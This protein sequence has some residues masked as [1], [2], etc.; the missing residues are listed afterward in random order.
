MSITPDESPRGAGARW[1]LEQRLPLLIIVL[2]AAVLIGLGGAAHQEVREANID[3]AVEQLQRIGR[4]LS[5]SSSRGGAPRLVAL[6][7]LAADPLLVRAVTAAPSG[8]AIDSATTARVTQR[9][10]A[11]HTRTDSTLLGWELWTTSGAPRLRAAP[12]ASG[13]RDSA[14]LAHTR[15]RVAQTDSV[16]R[17]PFYVADGRVYVWTVVPVRA[18]GR[19][20]GTLAEHRRLVGSARTE[21]TI[22]ALTGPEVR[23]LITSDGEPAWVTL[24]GTP[25]EA[26]FVPPAANDRAERVRG[27][28]GTTYYAVQSAIAGTPWRVVLFTT[29]AAVLR[30][31]REFLRAML[32]A[33]VAFLV[34]GTFGA[35]LLSRHVTRPLRRITRAAA[36]LAEGDYTQRVPLAD[37]AELESLAATF[38][39][40]AAA[41][42]QAHGE[43]AERN[44]ALQRANE[45]K[46]RFLAVMSH[47]LRTPL[48][49]IGG[50][51]E[52][53]EL[54][55]RGPVTPEQIEDLG[56]IRRSKDYLLTIIQDILAFSRGD[57]GYLTV[58]V[59]DVPVAAVLA[60]A[61]DTLRPQYA[62][63]GIVLDVGAVPEEQVVRA[64]R[65][66]MQQILLNLLAN[67]LRFT[68]PGGTVS[69]RSVRLSQHVRI[70]VNDTGIGIAPER[71]TDIFEP[72]VQVDASLTRETGGA[73]LGLAIARD[74]AAAMG[75]SLTVASTV[76]EGSTFTLMLPLATGAEPA[77]DATPVS[78]AEAV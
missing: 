45:A 50:Y 19:T 64:D 67:A 46:S 71:L 76:G 31:S 66:K 32:I 60:D 59:R 25:A 47:E 33:G 24:E 74:L 55:L 61:V 48:N 77:G 40:M 51:T 27:R 34:L 35:W 75:G 12:V 58:A 54:G 26:P 39:T 7:A 17:S 4:E 37:D 1:S 56:R 10:A 78:D 21:Q 2:L 43:L 36:A 22:R 69:V 28:D 52:L 41:L 23:L 20:V 42:G 18:N 3:R 49:A 53:M 62:A 13:A 29:E 44:A 11:A 73:G 16:Q 30:R 5:A 15:S 68:R 65:E 8:A 57:A 14:V 9:L 38:N 6:Q 72:F 63:K 70:D